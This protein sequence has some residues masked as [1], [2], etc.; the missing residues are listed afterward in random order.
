M[1]VD[2]TE[3]EKNLPK[4]GFRKEREGHHIYFY[5]EYEGKET[6]VYT[7]ISH[8]SK[9]KDISGDLLTSMRKQLRLDS[10]REAVDLFKCPLDKDGLNTALI[11]KG[12]FNP[13]S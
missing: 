1:K 6:G 8:S 12:V 4:K 11:K 13:S 2:R 5:H 7:Y 3:I 9:L 10:N